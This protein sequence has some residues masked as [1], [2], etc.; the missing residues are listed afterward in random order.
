VRIVITALVA[1]C[2]ATVGFGASLVSARNY[3]GV[4]TLAIG[5]SFLAAACFAYLFAK[6]GT[7]WRVILGIV[8][9][10]PVYTIVDSAARLLFHTR[11]SDLL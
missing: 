2:A 7:T 1:C 11:V 10:V 5:A 3:V 8:L 9:L 4:L 6:S